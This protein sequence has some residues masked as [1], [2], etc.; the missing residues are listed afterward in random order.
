MYIP[1]SKALPISAFICVLKSR[2]SNFT[3]S[4]IKQLLKT[5]QKDKGE[6]DFLFPFNQRISKD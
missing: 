3:R 1:Y 4:L 2:I 6:E 5:H